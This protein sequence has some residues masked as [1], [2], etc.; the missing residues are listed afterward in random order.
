MLVKPY[1]D[2]K[3]ESLPSFLK[4]F[5]STKCNL[6]KTISVIAQLKKEYN[7]ALVKNRFNPNAPSNTLSTIVNPSI[8]KLT[9]EEDKAGMHLLGPFFSTTSSP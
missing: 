9:E 2:D 8:L 4:F 7:A 3:L 6:T 1:I 5:W